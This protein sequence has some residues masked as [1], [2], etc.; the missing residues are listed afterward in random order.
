LVT[1][2]I[3]RRN[4]ENEK[5]RKRMISPPDLPPQEGHPDLKR[6][7][8]VKPKSTKRCENR[9]LSNFKSHRKDGFFKRVEGHGRGEGKASKQGVRHYKKRIGTINRGNPLFLKERRNKQTPILGLG[10]SLTVRGGN[11][12]HNEC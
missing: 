7:K 8:G 10:E 2:K 1:Q 11:P 5:R 12:G 4:R 6:K 3:G 9:R